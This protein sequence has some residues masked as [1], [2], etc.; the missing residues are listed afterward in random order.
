MASNMSFNDI[1]ASM[2]QNNDI[3]IASNRVLTNAFNQHFASKQYPNIR[4][5]TY[6]TS[7]EHNTTNINGI[8]RNVHIWLNSIERYTPPHTHNDLDRIQVAKHFTLPDAKRM[9]EK[10]ITEHG[11]NWMTLKAKFT[12]ISRPQPYDSFKIMKQIRNIKKGPDES[13]QSV[14]MRL[15]DLGERLS[16]DKS[17]EGIVQPLLCDSF[18]KFL[19][20]RFHRTLSAEDKQS[21]C[22]VLEKALLFQIQNPEP[23]PMSKKTP[24]SEVNLIKNTPFAKLVSHV[25]PTS[26]RFKGKRHHKPFTYHPPQNQ[27]NRRNGIDYSNNKHRGSSHRN[28]HYNR[29]TISRY[30]PDNTRFTRSCRTTSPATVHYVPSSQRNTSIGNSVANVSHILTVLGYLVVLQLSTIINNAQSIYANNY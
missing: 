1:T 16:L 23:S 28:Y 6:S 2:K 29:H 8:E 26:S 14:V 18:A 24:K 3:L 30:G 20:K 17:Y 4:H 22:Y 12:A 15:E 21:L 25:P 13:L 5:F 11:T 10:C 27:T 19:P 7:N 9:F